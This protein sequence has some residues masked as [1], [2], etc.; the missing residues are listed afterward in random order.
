MMKHRL[1]I[2]TIS[3]CL[4]LFG[5]ASATAA[6]SH[7]SYSDLFEEIVKI[8]EEHFYN[9]VQITQDFPTI[10][11][12]YR[13]QLPQISTQE[14]FSTLVNTMLRELNASHTYYLTPENYE[15]YQLGSLFSRIPEIG[16]LFQG[17]EVLYP[18]VGI[19]TQILEE[20]VYIVAVLAGSV[21]EKAGLLKGDEILSVN[22]KPYTPIASLRSSVGRDVAFEIRRREQTEPFTIVMQPVLVNPKQEML[23]AQKASVQII[24]RAGTHIGYI[25][26]YSYAG[27]E[28]HQELLNALVW[29]TLK[30]ADALIIDL[31]Y[32]LGGAWPYYLNIFNRNIPMLTMHERDGT[33]TV[34]DS[35]WRKPAVYLV[36]ALSRSGKELLAFGARKYHLATVIGERTPGQTLGGRLFPLSNGDALFL[37]VQSCRIDGV[38]LEGVGV[39]PD[40]EVPFDVRYC[41]GHDVQLEKALEYLV[42]QLASE[43]TG[44]P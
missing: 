37:A 27:D 32:G 3:V 4:T 40:I 30:E 14:A 31:R 25:H 42:E 5:I 41:A 11:D 33:E 22:G 13:K 6:V 12:T 44:V 43:T 23:E 35:Q 24:E 17:Q 20:R 7:C 16:E 26:L 21:A 19:L 18:T 34:V 36:N 38:N 28:Y 10:K 1:S 15:Y 9:P 39:P 2:L 8:V 29:G